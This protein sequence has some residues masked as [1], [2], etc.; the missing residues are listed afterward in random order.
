MRYLNPVN[1]AGV[2]VEILRPSVKYV[3]L[4]TAQKLSVAVVLF[5]GILALPH[6]TQADVAAF[7]YS[8]LKTSFAK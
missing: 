6:G 4:V 7:Q 2:K 1:C 3:V 5:P 8:N